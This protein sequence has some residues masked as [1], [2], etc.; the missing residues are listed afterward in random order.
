MKAIRIFM[1]LFAVALFSSGVAAATGADFLPVMGITT[2]ISLIMPP[3]QGVLFS[4]INQEIWTGAI[5]EEFDKEDQAGFLNEIPDES[6]YVMSSK[7]EHEVIHLNDIGGDP[8]VLIDNT[9]YP[10]GFYT[11][12]DGDIA[13]SLKK[14]QTKATKVSDDEIRFITYD[15]IKKV[16]AKHKNSVVTTKH[17]LAIHALAP[18]AHTAATPVLKTTGADDG[19]G[20]NMLVPKD[21][22]RLKRAF[23]NAEVPDEKRIL[24]LST[25]HHNDLLEWD[26]AKDTARYSADESGKLKNMI[27]GFKV[28]VYVANP[29]FSNL[30]FSKLA[31]GATPLA[32]HH[33]ASVAFAAKEAFKANGSTKNYTDEPDTQSQAWMY[34]IRH[35]AIVLPKKQRAIG[36][37]ISVPAA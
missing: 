11:Q 18:G 3:V 25:D 28:Y 36:A 31:F 29:Y 32:E 17:K 2:G 23:D 7:G 22:L 35:Y 12:V 16:Q 15:K 26:T 9:T 37:I 27:Y 30:T 4:G 34:N 10:I 1:A 21:I 20:R 24:V 14:F 19:T 33:R 8:E 6:Q 5:V 13:I